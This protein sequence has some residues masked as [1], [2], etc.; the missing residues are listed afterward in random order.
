MKATAICLS[1]ALVLGLPGLALAQE[2]ERPPLVQVL[3]LTIDY[4]VPEIIL[5][6]LSFVVVF[7]VIE[8]IATLVLGA[9]RILSRAVMR[10]VCQL[11]KEKTLS[12][13]QK[14]EVL[15]LCQAHP[16]AFSTAVSQG[17]QR[18]GRSLA[19]I[20]TA[21]TQV[22][23]MEHSQLGRATGYLQL[24]GR[25]APFIGLLGTVIGVMAAFFENA[26][27]AQGGHDALARG[28]STALITT[29][30]GI[31][32]TV[33]AIATGHLF[34]QRQNRIFDSMIVLLLSFLPILADSRS[35]RG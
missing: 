24:V 9:D 4:H 28:I 15:S 34:R 21:C 25:L 11:S 29:A 35:E 22:L 32:V 12:P 13:A 33:L 30:G 14:Q 1:L 10:L 17:V 5:L 27:R 6:L 2:T 7:L 26:V 19:E 31:L 8:R 20:E 23:A 16:S 18:S 3:Q